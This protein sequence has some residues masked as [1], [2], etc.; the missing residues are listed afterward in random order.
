VA[1]YL[2]GAPLSKQHLL[3]RHAQHTAHCSSCQG[4]LRNAQ[5]IST[6]AHRLL[7]A[8]ATLVPWL[9]SSTWG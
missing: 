7:L 3:D 6:I 1:D 2:R 8:A 5:R 4:A 9:V